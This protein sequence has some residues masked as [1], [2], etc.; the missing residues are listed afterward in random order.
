MAVTLNEKSR[1]PEFGHAS[2]KPALGLRWF[3]KYHNDLLANDCVIIQGQK[4]RIPRYY[5]KKLEELYPEKFS[6]YKLRIENLLDE[7]EP[8]WDD[9]SNKYT[10]SLSRFA[11][12]DTLKSS[13]N[14]DRCN[15]LRTVMRSKKES[16]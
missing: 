9:L 14:H 2:K 13:D 12:S 10:I 3:N 15:Y 1:T 11:N 16:L 7:S 8:N 5:K 4:Y 6:S